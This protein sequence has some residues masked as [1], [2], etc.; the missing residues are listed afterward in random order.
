MNGISPRI[1]SCALGWVKTHGHCS[2]EFEERSSEI[3]VMVRTWERFTF[4][5]V[6]IAVFNQ[7][8][9]ETTLEAELL[10]NVLDSAGRNASVV[11]LHGGPHVVAEVYGSYLGSGYRVKLVEYPTFDVRLMKRCLQLTAESAFGSLDTFS[12]TEVVVNRLRG[13]ETRH[14]KTCPPALRKAINTNDLSKPGLVEEVANTV[15][16]WPLVLSYLEETGRKDDG[17]SLVVRCSF[18]GIF[19]ASFECTQYCFV[20]WKKGMDGYLDHD[21]LARMK[22]RL[23]HL[24]LEVC[25]CHL[26]ILSMI[27]VG[28]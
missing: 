18:V 8:S 10:G 6:C 21:Q 15:G 28:T 22:F 23:F 24:F 25:E 4:C 7:F 27:Y 9:S 2:I 12:M 14:W 19:F 5:R 16:V 1:F 17:H 20:V 13:A 26:H 11:C 3:W